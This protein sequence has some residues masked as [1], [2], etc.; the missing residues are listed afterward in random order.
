M[1]MHIKLTEFDPGQGQEWQP[2]NYPH[3]GWYWIA[4]GRWVMYVSK[5]PLQN[6]LSGAAW[7][8]TIPPNAP[9]FMSH[10]Q[11]SS[12]GDI[13]WVEVLKMV[14]IIEHPETAKELLK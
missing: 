14:A 11:P 2:L 1:T 6:M 9:D 8:I 4:R 7:S 5:E 3:S 10:G 12:V 13:P